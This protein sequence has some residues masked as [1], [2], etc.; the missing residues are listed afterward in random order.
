MN[1]HYLYTFNFD[2]QAEFKQK[3]LGGA[4]S[5]LHMKERL[6]LRVHLINVQCQETSIS[7]SGSMEIPRGQGWQMQ[8]FLRKSMEQN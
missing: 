8:K 6:I 7:P 2:L 5:L 1:R 3:R 4:G